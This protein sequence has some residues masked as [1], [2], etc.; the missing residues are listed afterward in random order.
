V[1]GLLPRAINAVVPAGSRRALVTLICTRQ[2]G[3]SNDGYADA[4]ALS[5]ELPP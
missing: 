2:E 5:L 1:T 3:V 4:I